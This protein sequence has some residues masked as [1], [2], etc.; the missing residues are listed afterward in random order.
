LR[1][2]IADINK[3][4]LSIPSGTAAN[5]VS[6]YNASIGGIPFN[7]NS[8]NKKYYRYKISTYI[9]KTYKKGDDNVDFNIELYTI[10]NG[11]ITS[12]NY[13]IRY[14][15]PQTSNTNA[16]IPIEI[17]ITIKPISNMFAKKIIVKTYS[18]TKLGTNE[19]EIFAFIGNGIG[20]G[21][22]SINTFNSITSW[23]TSLSEK[24]VWGIV[25]KTSEITTLES[26]KITVDN[27][28]TKCDDVSISNR[29]RICDIKDLIRIKNTINNA[30]F[31]NNA[32]SLKKDIGITSSGLFPLS[33]TG[34]SIL[35]YDI[36]DY[37]SYES[38]TI[39]TP[40]NRTTTFNILGNATKYI[41]F[42][43]P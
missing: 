30:T 33:T 24:K 13:D 15:F 17:Y 18:R 21:S 43:I 34:S 27:I 28:V 7:D 8:N 23:N 26:S 41:Y 29:T 1:K 20:S 35:N 39:K 37:I 10:Q 4:Q 2:S 36:A 42:A 6:L 9:S 16:I 12:D 32:P 5:I 31:S 3:K 11:F 40:A 22:T 38:S 19:A 25:E 14:V